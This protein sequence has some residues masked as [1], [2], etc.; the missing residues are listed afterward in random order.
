MPDPKWWSEFP[1]HPHADPR[2][3]LWESQELTDDEML[4]EIDRDGMVDR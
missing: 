3:S 1:E 2:Y 4:E